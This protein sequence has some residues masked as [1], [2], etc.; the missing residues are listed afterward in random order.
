MKRI[1]T[2]FPILLLVIFCSC[3]KESDCQYQRLPVTSL[4]KEY[5]C[6]NTLHEMDVSLPNNQSSGHI[7]VSSQL[8][9]D[10][11]VTSATCNP[12]IDFSAYDLV[13][14]KVVTDRKFSSAGYNLR[15]PCSS[16]TLYLVVVLNNPINSPTTVSSTT[17]GALIPKLSDNHVVDVVTSYSLVK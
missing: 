16:D 8:Q 4:E 6:S 9:Y 3:D 15:N 10:N 7:I 1:R 2:L 13:I 17:Y 12:Q 14:G 11:L 5:G